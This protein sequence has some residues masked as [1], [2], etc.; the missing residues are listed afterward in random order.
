MD[1]GGVMRHLRC[2]DAATHPELHGRWIWF[3]VTDDND[4]IIIGKLADK[5]T[6]SGNLWHPKQ[7][8]VAR[9]DWQVSSVQGRLTDAMTGASTNATPIEPIIPRV[10]HV[11]D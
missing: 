4:D 5:G 6:S 1:I 7:S 2:G 10:N 3:D 8:D 11:T 9:T